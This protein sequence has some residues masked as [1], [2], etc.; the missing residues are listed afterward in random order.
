MKMIDYVSDDKLLSLMGKFVNGRQEFYYI[1]HIDNLKSILERGLYSHRGVINRGISH[2]S[3]SDDEV[4][5]KR[6]AK[7]LHD[8]VNLYINPR[9]AMMFRIVQNTK[10]IVILSVSGDILR[11][12]QDVKISIGNAASDSSII[13]DLKNIKNLDMFFT[14]VRCIRDWV[15]EY[16][17]IDISK[18]VETVARFLS[19]KVFLQSEVLVRD[20]ISPR[21]F[22]AVYVPDQETKERLRDIDVHVIVSP[23]FFFL[24]ER[25]EQ[26]TENIWIVQGDMFTSGMQTLTVS[27]N[28]VGV[29]GKGLAS[30]FK[31]M[32]PGAYVVYERLCKEKKLRLGKPFIYVPEEEEF[33]EE[34]KGRRFLFFPTKGHWKEKSRLPMIEKGLDWFI[35]HYREYGVESI[36]FPALGCGLGGLRWEDV[37]P[38]MVQKLSKVDISVE[39]YLPAEKAPP[40]EYFSPDFYF[41]R[42]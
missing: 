34:Y 24:P 4:M 39:I 33:E 35:E 17:S 22:K 38:L 16:S 12:Y 21:Y 41:K 2:T 40:G 18:Y 32:Y 7:G 36:A 26:V 11:D 23:D 27:V 3:I 13:V 8:Y 10:N 5:A 25:K 42:S 37:G 1:T 14:D 30:R 19:P 6:E 15:S 20:H 28:T 9:N 29:M 31:Y